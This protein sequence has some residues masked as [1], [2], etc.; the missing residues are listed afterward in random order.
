MGSI[1]GGRG[2]EGRGRE[3]TW[4]AG[5]GDIGGGRAARNA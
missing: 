3:T 5:K 2:R 1:S 4:M